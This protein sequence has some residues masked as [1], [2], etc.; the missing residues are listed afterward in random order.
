M[1]AKK[2]IFYFFAN[3]SGQA[4]EKGATPLTCCIKDKEQQAEAKQ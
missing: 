1:R 3:N 2:S 4:M